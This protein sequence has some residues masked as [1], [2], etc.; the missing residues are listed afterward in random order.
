[1]LLE[2]EGKQYKITV[3]DT[4][5]GVHVVGVKD[6]F[7]ELSVHH[8]IPR[9]ELL[10][11]LQINH[12]RIQKEAEQAVIA[13]TEWMEIPLFD[14]KHI[15]KVDTKTKSPY[16]RANTVFAPHLPHTLPQI[17]QLKT[18][19]L[20]QSILEIIG[21]WEERLGFM[22]GDI[23][24][25]P[26]RIKDYRLSKDKRS[27][28]YA[29]KLADINTDMLAYIIATSIFDYLDLHTDQR[30]HLYEK[31]VRDWKYK[32]KVYAYEKGI[33]PQSTYHMR[34]SSDV[35]D[36]SVSEQTSRHQ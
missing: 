24:V 7:V 6:S 26:L 12:T 8:Q 3:S 18:N 23:S 9:H 10:A 36:L 34:S 21:D 11:Y 32:M 31:Y 33:T 5:V 14:K 35:L 13:H 22:L 29:K 16:L 20:Q 28:T 4:T 1:M 19:L 25:K 15:I 2:V 17:E 27:I 30:T